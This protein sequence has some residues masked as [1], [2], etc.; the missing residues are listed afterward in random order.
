MALEPDA[1]LRF[2][3]ITSASKTVARGVPFQECNI[4]RALPAMKRDAVSLMRKKC[5]DDG[6]NS[7][8]KNWILSVEIEGTAWKIPPSRKELPADRTSIHAQACAGI[9][10]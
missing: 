8:A 3:C 7:Y 4:A 9:K 5:T 10:R 6:K 2:L 1:M